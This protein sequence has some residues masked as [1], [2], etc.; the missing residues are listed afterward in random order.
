[1]F[2]VQRGVSFFLLLLWSAVQI[3]DFAHHLLEHHEEEA[4]QVGE[5]HYCSPHLELEDCDLCLIVHGT[6]DIPIV[7]QWE[8]VFSTASNIEPCEEDKLIHRSFHVRKGRAP[9][10]MV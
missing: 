5:Y 3:G 9:P 1:M 8:K 4:C 7:Y 2:R 6:T 10:F